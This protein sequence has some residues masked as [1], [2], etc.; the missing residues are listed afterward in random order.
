M[1]GIGLAALVRGS[2]IEQ[3]PSNSVQ[4][5]TSASTYYV[6][7]IAHIFCTTAIANIVYYLYP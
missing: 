2:G 7:I 6:A 4:Y 5:I 3:S 1:G